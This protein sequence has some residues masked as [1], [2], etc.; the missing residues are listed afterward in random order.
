MRLWV[1]RDR[2]VH[3]IVVVIAR[4]GARSSSLDGVVVTAVE[5]QIVNTGQAKACRDIA[6]IDK[7]PLMGL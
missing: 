3:P 1:D 4:L 5:T 7:D 2:F 6:N